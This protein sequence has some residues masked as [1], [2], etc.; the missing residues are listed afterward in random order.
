MKKTTIY[1]VLALLCV[2]FWARAQDNKAVDVT[3]KGIQ[4]GQKVPDITINNLH[5]YK[6]A[7]GKPATIAKISDFKGKLLILDFWATWCSPC[8]AMIPKMDSLQK[9]FG[10]KIQFLSITY[11]TEKE[12]LPFLSKLEQQQKKH[13]NLPV[14]M[15]ELELHKLFPHVYLPHYVWI[16]GNGVVKAI[17]GFEAVN[18]INVDKAIK[19]SI[20]LEQKK[21]MKIRYDASKPFLINGNGGDGSNLIYHSVFTGFTDGMPAGYS[22]SPLLSYTK[23][24]ITARNLS[25]LQLYKLAYGGD[26]QYFGWNKVI[27]ET[28]DAAKLKTGLTGKE[29]LDWKK[30]NNS[31]SYEVSVPAHLANKIF[32]LMVDDINKVIPQYDANIESRKTKCYVLRKT[33]TGDKMKSIGGKVENQFSGLGC[34]LKNSTLNDLVMR[35]NVFYMQNSQYPIVNGTGYSYRVD[36]E[37]NA[38]LSD[39]KA[40]NLALANY[41]LQFVLED[42]DTDMLVVRD[43]E[44][45]KSKI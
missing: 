36:M 28:R 27:L 3:L 21:D 22:I 33:T 14:V 25:I 29:L 43:S 26:K 42:F 32:S 41:D 4:I 2:D 6:D 1:I 45:Q 17:T 12:V 10:D 44:A 19:N 7:N 15:A 35:L 18:E 5:N 40:L 37:I 23:R 30:A 39:M 38:D 31:Y 8:V 16:D 34:I 24:K 20:Q 11:Q 13:Y 9:A